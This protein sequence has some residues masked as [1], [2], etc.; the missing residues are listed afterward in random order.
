MKR[1]ILFAFVLTFLSLGF[2]QAQTID[3]PIVIDSLHKRGFRGLKSIINKTNGEVIGHYVYYRENQNLAIEF[4]DTELKTYKKEILPIHQQAEINEAVYNGQDLMFTV[5]NRNG[6]RKAG[7]GAYSATMTFY[8]YSIEGN[9]L[10]TRSMS[11]SVVGNVDLAIYPCVSDATFYIVSP[12]GNAFTIEKVSNSFQTIWNKNF[13]PAKGVTSF[14]AVFSG[15]DRLVVVAR[16]RPKWISKKAYAELICFNDQTGEELFKTN[17]YDDE[18]T[19]M[20][21]QILIDE[22]QNIVAAGE[23]FKGHKE[24]NVNSAGIFIKKVSPTGEDLVYNKQSWKDGIQKQLKK[25]KATIS[26]KNK[27]LFHE[28]VLSPDG[29][30]QVIGETF[31]ASQLAGVAGAGDSQVAQM[32]RLKVFTQA[33]ISGRYIGYLDLD[34]SPGTLTIQDFVIFNFD[35]DL[36]LTNVNKIAKPN[37]TKIYTYAPY[38][39]IGGLKKAKIVADFGFFDYSFTQ[40]TA[41]GDAKVLVYNAAYSKKPHMGVVKIEDGVPSETKQ[42]HFK[43]LSGK[44]GSGKRGQTGCAPSLPGKMVVYYFVKN[45]KD[46]NGKKKKGKTTG[47]VYMYLQDIVL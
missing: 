34:Y 24:R 47:K 15:N 46:E 21:S 12:T 22:D 32:Q 2:A 19:A 43:E 42:I 18:L 36:N 35:K 37:Y 27:V 14:E 23:Y 40:Q 13:V 17:L 25:T 10:G 20:P 45:E 33:A 31:S 38:D 6:T 5:I 7:Q 16:N 39:M 29:G 8:T 11:Y 44:K 30:Y 41:D 3:N 26:F 28:M 1:N 4:M 9:Q